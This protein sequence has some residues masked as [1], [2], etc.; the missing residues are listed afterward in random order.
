MSDVRDMTYD[1]RLAYKT[2]AILALSTATMAE[3]GQGLSESDQSIISRCVSVAYMNADAE[4]RT[5]RLGDLHAILLEQREPEARYIALR[6]E[7]YV[8]GPL[9]LFN[10]ESNVGF[11]NRITNV[12]FKNLPEDMRAFGIIVVLECMCNRAYRGEVGGAWTWLYIDEVQSLFSH[13]AVI[14]YFSRLWSEGRKYGLIC[15]GITQN[16]VYMLDHASA[17][18][19][20]FNA[21]FVLLHKQPPADRRA[22]ADMLGL[23]EQE[24][25]YIDESVKPGEGLLVAEGARIPIKDDFPKGRLYDIFT[26]K[27]DEVGAEEGFG[28]WRP[29]R[30][31]RWFPRRGPFLPPTY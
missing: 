20:M 6:Y 5:P 27:P 22:W 7:R 9:A 26:T 23:S 3:G 25:A 14:T 1:E 2:D 30:Q 15:T 11:G 28:A 12:D 4:D 13:P 16:S 19:I 24:C 18:N 29:M 21:D 31:S 17:R 10:H 8:E